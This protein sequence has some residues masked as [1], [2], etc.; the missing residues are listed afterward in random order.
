[1]DNNNNQPLQNETVNNQPV[2]PQQPEQPEMSGYAQ[3]M[4]PGQTGYAQP[5]Q[6]GQT[7]RIRT[8][9]TA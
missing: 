9:G 4:Q 8:A 3:P 6:Q 7:D 1:M 5:M 2:Q